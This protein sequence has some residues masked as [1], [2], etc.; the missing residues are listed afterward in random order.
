MRIFITVLLL[1]LVSFSYAQDNIQTDQKNPIDAQF[2]SIINESNN[3][4]DYKVVK[5]VRLNELQRNTENHINGLNE[6]IQNLEN[7]INSQKASIDSL[8]EDLTNTQNELA[9]VNEEKGSISFLGIPLEKGTYNGIVWSIIALLVVGLGFFIMQFK[10]SNSQTQVAK[11]NLKIAEDELE[12]LRRKA[13]EKEQKLGRML[14]GER[15][16]LTRIKQS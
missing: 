16:K 12:E 4:Q 13:L 1:S 14:Q 3:Y 7:N 15:N 9:K 8:E 10:N 2:E 5:K 11:Q 6:E